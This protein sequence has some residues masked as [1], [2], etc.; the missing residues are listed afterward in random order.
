MLYKVIEVLLLLTP[1]FANP[2][3]STRRFFVQELL[4]HPLSCRVGVA[5]P[6]A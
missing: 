4:E 5:L 1:H 2:V 6:N 3:G